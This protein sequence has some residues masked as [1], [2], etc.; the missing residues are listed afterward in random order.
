MNLIISEPENVKLLMHDGWPMMTINKGQ[1]DLNEP[2]TVMEVKEGHKHRSVRNHLK[3]IPSWN[4]SFSI[5][6]SLAK[7]GIL[8]IEELKYN[9]HPPKKKKRKIEKKR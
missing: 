6:V 2:N 4:D 9:P 8:L 5:L 7:N 1:Q 3:E